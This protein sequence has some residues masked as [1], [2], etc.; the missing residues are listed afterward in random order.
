[1]NLDTA[2]NRAYLLSN[3]KATA[4]SPTRYEKFKALANML[5]D[6]WLSEPDVQWSSRYERVEL[7]TISG[8]R[9]DMD[10]SIYELSQREGD[11]VTVQTPGSNQ[12]TYWNIVT[13]EAF[14]QYRYDNS[15][16]WIGDELVFSRPFNLGDSQYQGTVTVPGIMKLDPLTKGTDEIQVDDPQWLVYMMAGEQVRNTVT[17]LNQ[18][19]TLVQKANNIMEKM[20]QRNDAQI[21]Y[22]QMAPSVMGESWSSDGAYYGG[23]RNS[24]GQALGSDD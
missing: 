7:G 9:I 24:A 3:G 18:F 21:N 4:P 22:V 10:D 2:I 16:A 1:M 8:D 13:P 6:D 23:Y 19:S 20:K 11:Y 15:V 5:Q 12:L 17:K 14:R